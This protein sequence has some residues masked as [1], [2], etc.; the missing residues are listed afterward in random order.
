M[1]SWTS[2]DRRLYEQVRES[3]LQ[4]GLP[5]SEAEEI[6]GRTVNKHRRQ[7][8][9]TPNRRTMGTGNPNAPLEA[10][11]LDELRNLAREL[12]VPGRS[13]MRKADLIE[14]IRRE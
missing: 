13:R 11:T 8:G 4:R 6:A 1:P 3:E 7:E 2:E 12:G 10:H 14:A 9:R 5:E